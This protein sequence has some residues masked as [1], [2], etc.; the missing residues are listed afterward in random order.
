[1][2]INA[3]RAAHAP[4]EHLLT[5]LCPKC[6]RNMK[7]LCAVGK[8]GRKQ[9]RSY[10]TLGALLRAADGGCKICAAAIGEMIWWRPEIDARRANTIRDKFFVVIMTWE[11]E[12]SVM[13]IIWRLHRQQHEIELLRLAGSSMPCFQP[14]S[15]SAPQDI[16]SGLIQ[17]ITRWSNEEDQHHRIPGRWVPTRLIRIDGTED[18]RI[19]IVNADADEA[20]DGRYTA[21]SHRW[22]NFDFLK[23]TKST[24]SELHRG[25]PVSRVAPNFR[26]AI[27]ITASLGIQY[28]WIDS[29]CI[30]QD[31]SNDWLFE[32]KYMAAVYSHASLTFAMNSGAD[33][34]ESIIDSFTEYISQALMQAD[35]DWF[36]VERPGAQG[37]IDTGVLASRG[38]CFQER[39][40][41]MRILHVFRSQIFWE[42]TTKLATLFSPQTTFPDSRWSYYIEDDAKLDK[43]LQQYSRK[44]SDRSR[45]CEQKDLAVAAEGIFQHWTRCLEAYTSRDLTRADDRMLAFSAILRL[46]QA[47]TGWKLVM[48]IPSGIATQCLLWSAWLPKSTHRTVSIAG[49]A[50]RVP[51]WSWLSL[52]SAI[53][54]DGWRLWG[55]T[56]LYIASSTFLEPRMD[57]S[58][59]GRRGLQVIKTYGMLFEAEIVERYAGWYASMPSLAIQQFLGISTSKRRLEY[60]EWAFEPDLAEVKI[61]DF[62]RT[63]LLPLRLIVQ[64]SEK[65]WTISGLLVMESSLHPGFYER[66]GFATCVVDLKDYRILSLPTDLEQRVLDRQLDNGVDVLLV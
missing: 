44:L 4:Y 62:A 1:M 27:R 65:R 59:D 60:L 25:I 39:L 13:R 57:L 56:T 11:V 28:I 42:T 20:Q 19:R 46:I 49:E 58:R 18:L 9:K 33:L 2:S 40:L 63:M 54:Y 24:I 36:I 51:S 10:S 48:G 66:H 7:D 29:L 17:Q 55:G 5:T 37:Y 43:A 3:S 6:D 32:A 22:P 50:L 16:Y 14:C 31:D 34:D 64:P 38:W 26:D 47:I 45:D 30:V 52:S 15:G 8:K 53:K 12:D 23:C 41:S 21:L 61:A 35:F